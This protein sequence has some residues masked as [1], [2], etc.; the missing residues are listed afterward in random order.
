MSFSFGSSHATPRHTQSSTVPFSS[1]TT[2]FSAFKVGNPPLQFSLF[3]HQSTHFFQLGRHQGIKEAQYEERKKRSDASKKGW[4]TRRKREE[5]NLYT[6][7]QIIRTCEKYV[8]DMIDCEM[9]G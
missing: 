5:S 4:V 2:P 6:Q 7:L 3:S 8:C 1:G 9:S